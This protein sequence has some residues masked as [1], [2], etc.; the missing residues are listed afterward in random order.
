MEF[1]IDTKGQAEL[2]NV[3][4]LLEDDDD[5]VEIEEIGK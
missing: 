4:K 1:I 3:D 2:Q 5:D